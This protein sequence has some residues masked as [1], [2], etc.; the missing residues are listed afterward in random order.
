MARKV[1]EGSSSTTSE[2]KNENSVLARAKALNHAWGEELLM[3]GDVIPEVR[4]FSI[5]TLSADYALNG[6]LPL[7]VIITFAGPAGGCKT[8]VACAAMAEFQREFPDKT[9]VY[10]DVESTLFGQIK[11]FSHMTGLKLDGEH[12][13]RLK[14]AGKPAE[15]IC[16]AVIDL[17][18]SDNIG[19][20]VFDSVKALVS[21]SDYENDFD[22]DNGMRASVAK[23]I[24]KFQRMMI[25]S[26][27]EK[28]N[29][30]IMINH[31]IVEPIPGTRAFKYSE[32]CGSSL[33][34]F[35]SMKIRFLPRKFCCGTEID[36]T[37]G[38]VQGEK[39]IVPDGIVASFAITKSRFGGI[40]RSGG[41]LIFR[42]DTG[43]DKAT[44][45]V[46]I[47]TKNNIAKNT[48]GN[49]WVLYDPMTGETFDD[50]NGE[51][52]TFVGKPKMMT[53]FKEHPEFVEEYS[54]VVSAYV[55]K[56]AKDIS[57]LSDKDIA[58]IVKISS[59]LD[60]DI[61]ELSE[62]D[63]EKDVEAE[64]EEDDEE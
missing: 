52:L 59:Q 15:E 50:E 6:G 44:D 41:K 35:P 57:L 19:M 34:Y 43:I 47:I 23:T 5:G 13:L 16:K 51:P 62:G 2:K 3:P 32:P 17:Q 27:E 24:G 20:I 63:M 14:C 8:L 58:K 60:N 25:G 18:A 12:F 31:S 53:Y 49:T 10:V 21:Q 9:C 29:T 30:L 46:E 38:K 45:L 39:G 55:N 40:D 48:K 61:S 37:E 56:E 28:Q 64:I 7:G 11:L 42:Y 22:K 33:N 4:K 1:K 36:L 26:L 54:K